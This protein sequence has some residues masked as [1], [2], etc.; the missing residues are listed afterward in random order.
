MLLVIYIAIFAFLNDI[1]SGGRELMP[2]VILSYPFARFLKIVTLMSLLLIWP[3]WL[4]N[5]RRSR[6]ERMGQQ[7]EGNRDQ[8]ETESIPAFTCRLC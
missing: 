2:G 4:W 3:I 8:G 7:L 1:G 5:R 6:Q